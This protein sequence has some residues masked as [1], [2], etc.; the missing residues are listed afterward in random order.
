MNEMPI[1]M[2]KSGLSLCLFNMQAKFWAPLPGVV[3]GSFAV[4]SGVLTLFL[5]ETLGAE[6]FDTIEEAAAYR[7]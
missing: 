3:C 5:P 7:K 4:T 2:F 1:I 6:L